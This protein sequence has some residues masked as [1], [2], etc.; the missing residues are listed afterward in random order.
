MHPGATPYAN[1]TKPRYEI[2][3]LVDH[4]ER[5]RGN[6]KSLLIGLIRRRARHERA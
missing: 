4:W 1:I 6:G 2:L 5:P 3:I